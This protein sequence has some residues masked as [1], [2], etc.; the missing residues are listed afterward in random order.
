MLFAQ[1]HP[2]R[3]L[4]VAPYSARCYVPTLS[5]WYRMTCPGHSPCRTVSAFENLCQP[6]GQAQLI[7]LVCED[8]QQFRP[9]AI[10]PIIQSL[11][12]IECVCL[13]PASRSTAGYGSLHEYTGECRR[14]QYADDPSVGRL[15]KGKRPPLPGT[16]ELTELLGY[17]QLL[18]RCRPVCSFE[19]GYR[20]AGLSN[21][22]I[23]FANV[24]SSVF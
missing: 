16:T 20:R 14:W 17:S 23:V 9:N 7:T 19:E 22:G 12:Q 4:I 15:P 2:Q 1:R 10:R 21:L 6:G 5:E 3:G 18:R 8:L 13:L 24:G 11:P